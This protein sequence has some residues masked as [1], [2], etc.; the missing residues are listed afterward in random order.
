MTKIRFKPFVGSQYNNT[1]CRI[2]ILGESH[3]LCGDDLLDY[4]NNEP[5]IQNIT[6]NVVLEFLNYKNNKTS[7]QKW[8]NTFTK[9][10]NI[11]SNKNLNT[12]ETIDFWNSCSFYNFV[13]YPT[14]GPR[15]SPTKEQFK[16]SLDA[17]L[18]ISDELK[19]NVIFIWGYRLW[20]NLPKDNLITVMNINGTEKHLYNNIPIKVIPHPSSNQFNYELCNDIQNFLKNI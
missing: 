13:Q 6:Q 10:G 7:F 17:F 8:M 9:F 5:Y 18:K 2:L 20:Q 16:N 15:I 11:V 14:T 1:N 4:E 12:M 3:Y 19:P